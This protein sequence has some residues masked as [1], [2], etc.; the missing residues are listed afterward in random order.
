MRPIFLPCFGCFVLQQCSRC[1][2]QLSECESSWSS[3]M[4]PW[5]RFPG[6]W[7]TAAKQ[8][9]WTHGSS[10]SL[11]ESAA[12]EC[13]SHMIL[14]PW[15]QC[16]SSILNQQI[17]LWKV[18]ALGR[19]HSPDAA[20]E[21]NGP[22]EQSQG[23]WRARERGESNQGPHFIPRAQVVTSPTYQILIILIGQWP[24]AFSP[25]FQMTVTLFL[26]FIAFWALGGGNYTFLFIYGPTNQM[27][28]FQPSRKG[29]LIAQSSLL[30]TDCSD[31]K[32]IWIVCF[33]EGVN[34]FSV[35]EEEHAYLKGKRRTAAG[36]QCLPNPLFPLMVKLPSSRGYRT[37]K[38]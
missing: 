2:S 4:M 35:W 8:G 31:W 9:A 13:Q 21:A 26:L 14:G 20:S 27:M 22:G 32:D 6:H 5:F 38:V 12:P 3:N 23:L 17:R 7:N 30:W 33:G 16:G 19:A 37:A 36:T 25:L 29:L 1:Y 18:S 15:K 24:C 34:V 11:R 28:H 10:D